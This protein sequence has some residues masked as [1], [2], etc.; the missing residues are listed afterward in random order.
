VE[1]E[2][3][4]PANY[5]SYRHAKEEMQKKMSQDTQDY[6]GE[7]VFFNPHNSRHVFR[8]GAPRED[9]G[10]AADGTHQVTGPDTIKPTVPAAL[11]QHDSR[12]SQSVR[13]SNINC[14]SL[15]KMLKV[16][17][18]VVQQMMIES[19]CSVSEEPKY[20]PLQIIS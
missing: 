10:T 16:V 19:N 8:V 9:R 1:G 3:L 7:G 5:L 12:K 6:N 18:T 11:P 13:A 14:L 2:K 20:W 15:D 17:V 4:H